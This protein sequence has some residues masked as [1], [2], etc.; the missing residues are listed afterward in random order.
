[1]F[2][3]FCLIVIL[4][5]TG[6][7]TTS[8]RVLTPYEVSIVPIDCWNKKQIVNWLEEQ[9]N[10]AARSP[11]LYKDNINAIKYKLWEIRTVCPR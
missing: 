1:M 3:V 7:S 9:L 5:I 11:S 10:Y 8:Y 2:K 4:T 6:C